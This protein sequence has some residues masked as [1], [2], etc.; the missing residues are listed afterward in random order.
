MINFT[1]F[2]S[3]KEEKKKDVYFN[4]EIIIVD[5]NVVPDTLF[6][7]KVNINGLYTGKVWAYDTLIGFWSHKF[8][9]YYIN[10]FNVNTGK[11]LY[12]LGKRGVSVREFNSIA[13]ADQ[14]VYEEQQHV[15]IENIITMESVLLNLEKPGDEIKQKMDVNVDH[16]FYFG[17][18]FVFIL[19]DSLFLGGNQGEKIFGGERF[20]PSSGI[21]FI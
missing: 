9:D 15:W 13:C 2:I 19:N 8:P 10:V 3:C 21:S 18:N 12:A 5:S 1:I 14:Y 17:F 16:E 7:E 4:G 11:F 6:G 20:V